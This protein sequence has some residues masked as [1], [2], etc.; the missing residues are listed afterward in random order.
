MF[1]ISNYYQ[2][3]RNHN[4]RVLDRNKNYG[5]KWLN[6]EV[7]WKLFTALLHI[8]DLWS[9]QIGNIIVASILTFPIW[10]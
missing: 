8:Q 7:S 4:N 3:Y 1:I 10:L 5:I 2:L 9:H 6:D